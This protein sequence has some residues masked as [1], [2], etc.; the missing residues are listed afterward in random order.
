M[1]VIGLY[2][3]EAICSVA[4]PTLSS[5]AVDLEQAGYNAA[6][7]LE[8]LMSGRKKMEGQVIRVEPTHVVARQST[9]TLAIN[10][11]DVAG[12][13]YYIRQHFNAPIQVGD[14]VE[15]TGASRRSLEIRFREFLKRSIMEEIM[16]V[17]IEHICV[18][19]IESEMSMERIS[20][21]SA[22]ESTSHMIQVFKQHKGMT[23]LAFRKLHRVT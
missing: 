2:N 9:D 16:R 19:L 4:N 23:P 21:T 10:D 5:I 1:A 12:A 17:R 22:F 11:R 7:L 8:E 6:E 20:E 15:A 18:M 14:V 13:L 3:D